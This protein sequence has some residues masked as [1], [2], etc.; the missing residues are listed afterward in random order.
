MYRIY[1]DDTALII[2]ESLPGG[3][4]NHQQISEDEFDFMKFYR[5]V[6][7]MPGSAN[8]LLTKDPK[9]FFKKIRKSFTVI[10]AAG[11]IV[12]NDENQFLFIFRK[13]KWDLPKGKL[14]E[15]EK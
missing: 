3:L 10:K 8:V 9:R 14:D 1:I 2:S 5:L 13:G 6:K 7:G 11:G 4:V 12:R 15:G